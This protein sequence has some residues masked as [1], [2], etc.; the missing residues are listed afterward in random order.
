MAIAGVPT[1]DLCSPAPRGDRG[2][3][4]AVGDG[5]ET[6]IDGVQRRGEAAGRVSAARGAS[7]VDID[8]AVVGGRGAAVD[9][10]DGRAGEAP[11]VVARVCAAQRAAVNDDGQCELDAGGGRADDLQ[12]IAS[13][14]DAVDGESDGRALGDAI[15]NPNRGAIASDPRLATSNAA[16]PAAPLAWPPAPPAPALVVPEPQPA[17][18][19]R[20]A[21]NANLTFPSVRRIVLGRGPSNTPYQNLGERANAAPGFGPTLALQLRGFPMIRFSVPRQTTRAVVLLLGIATAACS[22]STSA[23]LD[24]GGDGCNDALCNGTCVNTQTDNNNCGGC[25]VVCSA[26]APSIAQCTGGR[27]LV[28]LASGESY[29]MGIA[30]DVTS[31]YWASSYSGATMNTGSIRTVPVGGGSPT[32]LAS[33]QNN[34]IGI[35]ADGT[36]VY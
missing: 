27:C 34:P 19:S 29:P 31:V 10:A 4:V 32:T 1:R 18:I 14:G 8:R 28:T 11:V 7:G 26:I 5:D 25:G 2:V 23:K 6:A 22:S 12:G 36:T 24:A 33:A 3:K 20:P 15:G 30:V 16:P 13:S 17:A 21:N 35:A 9:D